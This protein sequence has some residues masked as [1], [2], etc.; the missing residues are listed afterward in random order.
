M[1][2]VTASYRRDG[3]LMADAL[4]EANAHSPQEV[5]SELGGHGNPC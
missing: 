5:G 2:T 3:G 4:P 1:P